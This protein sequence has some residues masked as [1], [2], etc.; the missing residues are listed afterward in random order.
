MCR[1]PLYIVHGASLW[2]LAALFPSL[3]TRHAPRILTVSGW[4]ARVPSAIFQQAVLPYASVNEARTDWRQLMW[5]TLS[6]SGAPWLSKLSNASTI[7]TVA[8]TLNAELW[9]ALGKL[10]GKASIEFR[11]EQ[12]PLIYD[13]LST[14]LFGYASCTGIS[15]TLVDALR[16]IGVPARLVGTPAWHGKAEDGN[17]NWVEVWLG[18]E[19]GWAFFEG[20]PA[21]AGETLTNPCDK[22]FCN[23]GHFAWV[24]GAG[25]EVFAANFDAPGGATY[26]MAWDPSN[27]GVAGVNRTSYYVSVCNQCR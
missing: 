7:E 8:M 13:P 23:P 16:T 17:H 22:W 2:Q 12:T 24:S 10:T 25:T 19:Q 18:A 3:L 26:P 4:A 27:A 15:L 20:A 5:D 1:A 11:G 21:G 14:I 6:T 9:T